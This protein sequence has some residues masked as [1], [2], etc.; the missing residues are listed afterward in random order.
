MAE[1]SRGVRFDRGAKLVIAFAL[2][3]VSG[4]VAQIVYRYTLPTDGWAVLTEEVADTNWSYSRNLVGAASDLQTDDAVF[5]VGG[6]SVAGT[7]STSYVTAPPGW[8][9]GQTVT[10]LVRR[11]G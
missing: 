11:E 1:P 5:E 3:L 8:Q 10:I 7:A 2:L 4:S 6:V 9:K